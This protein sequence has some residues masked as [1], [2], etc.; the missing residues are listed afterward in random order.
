LEDFNKA[1][2][3][4]FLLLKYRPRS[5]SELISRLRRKSFPAP[6]IDK[7]LEYLTELNYIDDREFSRLYISSSLAKGWGRKKIALGLAKLGIA[8][9]VSEE[10]LKDRNIF[11]EKLGILIR[12]RL[13]F[14]QG[15][16]NVYQKILRYLA[17][18]GF[19]YAD[20]ISEMRMMGLEHYED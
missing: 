11:R 13:K 20:I 15:K 7:V 16:K 12:K 2:N 4:A 19:D 6:L 10:F 14:Y 1:L 17:Q 18:R 8:A 5:K 9:E 3:Y